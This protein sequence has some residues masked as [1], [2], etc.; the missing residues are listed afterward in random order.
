MTG[1][2]AAALGAVGV[3]CIG[4]AA[5]R[6]PR[7]S[8]HS[9]GIPAEDPDTL[10]YVR[11]AAARDLVMG[12]MVLWSAVANDV[13]AMRAGLAMC[14]IAPLADVVLAAERRGAI[15]QLAIHASGIAGIAAA[16]ALTSRA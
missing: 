2:F 8:T 6:W 12:G 1:R 11:A 3:L 4:A 9:Y 10:A 5:L 13:P 7:Q 16:L 14:V 15:P